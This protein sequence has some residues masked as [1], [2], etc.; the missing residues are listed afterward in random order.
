MFECVTAAPEEADWQRAQVVDA[1]GRRADGDP[2][3]VFAR[4]PSHD[5]VR[6]TGAADFHVFDDRI[7]CHLLDDRHEYLVDIAFLGMV[8]AFWLERRGTPT[9]HASVA[10]VGDQAIG[11]LANKGG[12]K[13]STLAACMAAGHALLTDD[14]L[15]LTG[16][17]AHQRVE[18]GFPALRLWPEQVTHFVGPYEGLP[19]VHPDYDKR[20]VRVGAGGFGRFASTAAPLRRLYLPERL[21]ESAGQIRLEPL[22]AAEAVMT[23]LRHSFLPRE[24]QRFGWQPQR[25]APFSRLVGTVPVVRLRYP[26]GLDR[27]PAL[28][29]RLEQDLRDE[30]AT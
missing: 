29:S 2:D 5:V 11:F 17:G 13:T 30:P 23:L 18:R 8:L 27:L 19:V 28:V 24:V 26:S 6:I 7:V 16:A 22:P 10:I 4:L 12:G 3:F 20:R 15:A 21:P 14:L 9:L 1:Q 25:L